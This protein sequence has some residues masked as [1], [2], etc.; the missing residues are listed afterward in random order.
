MDIQFGNITINASYNATLSFKQFAA[1]G[2]F[3]TEKETK[4]A[5]EKIH[6]AATVV[7]VGDEV[8]EGTLQTRK[9]SGK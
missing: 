6:L 4:D 7:K 5:W 1:Q 3:K 9:E 8:I 2:F